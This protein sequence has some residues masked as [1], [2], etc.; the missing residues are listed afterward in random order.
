MFPCDWWMQII[1]TL[2]KRKQRCYKAAFLETKSTSD[3]N[4]KAT[5]VRPSN[6]LHWKTKSIVPCYAENT[7]P[8]TLTNFN[9]QIHNNTGHKLSKLSWRLIPIWE[10]TENP[11]V[12]SGGQL[13][14][15]RCGPGS[16]TFKWHEDG[17]AVSSLRV[18]FFTETKNP[19][20]S[21][22]CIKRKWA[23]Q[24]KIP[25]KCQD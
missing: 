13:M 15:E 9:L 19:P 3:Q 8:H 21:Q 14:V 20:T 24:T 16:I 2:W 4:L 12:E 22:G 17:G 25:Y 10:R 11:T 1:H 6:C 23:I 5:M 18:R 7:H